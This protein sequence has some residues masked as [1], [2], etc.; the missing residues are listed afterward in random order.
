M[1]R[2]VPLLVIALA[3]TAF[4]FRD[5]WLPTPPGQMNNLGYVEADS[6]LIGPLAGGRLVG[7]AVRKG[8]MV[9]KGTVLFRMDDAAAK[10][11]LAKA[12]AAVVTADAALANLQSGKRPAELAVYESQMQEA[13]ANLRLAEVEFS[14][15]ERLS[16]GGVTAETLYDAA[17]AKLAVAKAKLEQVAANRTVAALA[18]REAEIAGA[19]ARI[20][21][22]Q[23]AVAAIAVRLAELTVSAPATGHIVDVFFA[24]GETVTSGQPVLS[25]TPL[26]ALKL[27]V[28]VPQAQRAS[29]QVGSPM[30]YTCDGCP[31][32]LTATITVVATEPEYTPP[33]IYSQ[34]SRAKLVWRVEARPDRIAPE[35]SPGMPIEMV[36]RP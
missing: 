16:R 19:Q 36:P 34:G 5:L 32:G 26:G 4:W 33:V 9:V 3:G 30:A 7:I 29:A 1:K 28:Y 24:E 21:E 13:E 12:E 25:L 10:A 18:G 23:A 35:L 15:A 27:Y 20:A 22:A 6:R 31:P 11:D 14:R 8:E 2:L 17:K